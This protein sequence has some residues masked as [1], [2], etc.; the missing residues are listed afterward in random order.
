[1]L[2]LN[3]FVLSAIV[4][5]LAAGGVAASYQQL[6]QTSQAPYQPWSTF[7]SIPLASPTVVDESDGEHASLEQLSNAFANVAERIRPSVVSITSAKKVSGTRWSVRPFE[8]GRLSNPFPSPFF[9]QFHSIKPPSADGLVQQGTGT[10]FV[11]SE[12]GHILTNHHVIR[13]ADSLRVKLASG[14]SFEATV[15]GA[16][17]KTDLALLKVDGAEGL[18]P[19]RLGMSSSLRVGNW[20]VAAG[21]PFGLS[22]TITSGIVS[23]IGRTQVGIV[24]YENVI[25]TDA[26]I[27]PGNSGGPLVNLKGEVVGVNTAI[28]TRTGGYMGVG[29]AIPIDM[30]KSVMDD[31]IEHGRVV[32]GWLGVN[33]QNL[34]DGLAKS[35][36]ADS[37]Q[38]ALVSDVVENTPAHRAGLQR[39]D[40][41]LRLDDRV[42]K[43]VTDLRLQVA[44]TDPGTDVSIEVL[45]SGEREAI[46]VTIGELPEEQAAND[47]QPST[48]RQDLSVETLTGPMARRLGYDE[49]LQGVV[50][51]RVTP[52]GVAARAG[53]QPKDVILSVDGLPVGSENEFERTMSSRDLDEGVRLDVR[54]GQARLYL[55]AQR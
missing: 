8:G 28:M 26:A 32:R 50:V 35:F 37:T 9:D 10:G 19:A 14:K 20:V 34:N 54:R 39:G 27:N 17:P 1:M 3:K 25:Q 42:V 53:L 38:G 52:F 33:I 4:T 24:D 31:L 30:A 45:R 11:V 6:F 13:D 41:V 16:D 36:G 48:T 29:L 2:R 55:F 43:N 7:S 21:N 12:D 23:A 47:A 51:T 18:T 44:R 5:L 15:V 22:S 40:I 46:R 49:N